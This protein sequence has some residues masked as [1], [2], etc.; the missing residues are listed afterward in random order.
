MPH[1]VVFIFAMH[2]FSSNAF[3]VWDITGWPHGRP[4][5][6]PDGIMGPEGLKGTFLNLGAF[7]SVER[8]EMP[9]DRFNHT[10]LYAGI[11]V[12]IRATAQ[13]VSPEALA[14]HNHFVELAQTLAAEN[15]GPI[16]LGSVFVPAY[17][18]APPSQGWF[19]LVTEKVD[20]YFYGPRRRGPN[21]FR[22]RR[23]L[24]RGLA[25]ALM[26]SDVQKTFKV[27]ER[28]RIQARDTYFILTNNDR[29]VLTQYEMS[30]IKESREEAALANVRVRDAVL[31]G[32]TYSWRRNCEKVLGKATE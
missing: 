10:A 4:V 6:G 7:T 25:A 21:S 14:R 15:L 17:Y 8:E 12:T 9:A 3:A 28:F 31:D 27:L 32:L 18:N 29:A 19:A 22:A 30:P 26:I 23:Q 16:V 13:G 11:K 5:Q 1:L 20:G 24:P 2:L